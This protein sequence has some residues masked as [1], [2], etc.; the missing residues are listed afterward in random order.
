MLGSDPDWE[1]YRLFA[2]GEAGAIQALVHRCGAA[3]LRFIHRCL[4]TGQP[5]DVEEVFNDT[6]LA[7]WRD[8]AEYDPQQARFKTWVFF[9]ARCIALDRRRALAR[10]KAAGPLPEITAAEFSWS[11]LLQLDLVW[12][13]EELGVLDRQIVYLSDYLG[14][15]HREIAGR[16]GLQP[17]ALDTRLHRA[18]K[19]LRQV[20]ASWRPRGVPEDS[21]G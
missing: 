5:E 14:L 9:K 4:G 10:D 15:D 3:L 7:I 12:A 11:L 8:V 20:L 1:S 17:G 2:T 6:L 18:R 21:D 19:R 16:L 13:L